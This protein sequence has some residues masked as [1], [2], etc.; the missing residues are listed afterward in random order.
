ME[1]QSLLSLFSSNPDKYY[2]VSLFDDKGFKRQNC[3]LCGKYFWS[4]KDKESCPEHENYSFI[5]DPPTQKRL[6]FVNAWKELSS[7]FKKNNHEIVHRYPVVCRWREDLYFTIASIVDFQRVMNGKIVFEI[8]KNPLVVPQMCLRFNDIENVGLTGRHYTSFCMIGQTC[9]ADV[10]GG[11]WKDKCI[12]LDHSLLKDVF[13]IKSD[14]ITF[15]EDVW[16]GAGAF[17]YSLEYY[18]RGLELGNAVFTEFEGDQYNYR[19]L[20]NKI[21]DMGAGL[22]RLSW[23]TL[24]TP[25]SYDATFGPV[26]RKL[27]DKFSIDID[28]KSELLSQY[29]RRFSNMH[30]HYQDDVTLLKTNI[31][32]ELGLTFESLEKTISP[33]ETLS[34]IAD[35]SRTLMFAISDGCL[36]SN[37][38]GGYNLRIVL[39]RTLA[40]LARFG[41]NID[42][43][44]VMDMHIEQLE[45]MYPEL[46]E[47]KNDVRTIIQIESDR[48]SSSK[49][50]MYQIAN[51][52]I[53]SKKSPSTDDLIRMYESDGI[54]PDFLLESGVIEKIPPDF[55]V[56][57]SELHTSHES[58]QVLDFEPVTG[59]EPTRL[60]YYENESTREFDARVLKVLKDK[61]LILDKTAFYPRGG[62]QEPDF[63]SIENIRITD[64][65]KQNNIVLHKM[66][67][68]SKNLFVKNKVVHGII[69]STR[70]RSITK[71]HSATHILNSAARNNLGS[72][73]WQNSAFKDEHYARLDITHHSALTKEQIK[74]IEKTANEVVQKNLPIIINIHERSDAESRYTFR[75]YQGG[76]VPSNNVRIVNI[77]GWDVEACGGTHVN[78]TGEIGL[79]KIL[80]TERIQDGVVRLEFVSGNNALQ[81]VQSQDSQL[82][83]I[84]K[85]L[86]SSREK[87]GESF[88]KMI[89][90]NELIKRKL[91]AIVNKFSDNMASTIPQKATRTKVGIKIYG[92]YDDQVGDDYYIAL[93]EKSTCV[94][95][96]L[97]FVALVQDQDR[98]RVIVFAG[99]ESRKI[100][101]ASRIAKEISLVLGGTGGGGTDKFAQGGG[102][103]K[104]KV[105][106]CLKNLES[107]IT[108]ILETSEKNG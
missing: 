94:D 61:Y 32:K 67:T 10:A 43:A 38:G 71:N 62:G 80:R 103:D 82:H 90:E 5:G 29:F 74:Q 78:K 87:V 7:F 22:E 48:Y 37:V 46:K 70:R 53:K 91:R 92:T 107:L 76:A 49:E 77:D 54:T 41:W 51:S 11:Y 88:G 28:S 75:I 16:M 58:K 6:D 79:I 27:A 17:G 21:I 100:L 39:R 106:D 36:P 30:T 105:Q 19:T 97:V 57:L 69:D 47:H 24:G 96:F 84:A 40:L 56:K 89:A 14:E 45:S 81:Y 1:K 73:V 8:P 52:M 44:E 59:I 95:P 33:F 66:Q 25:T 64:V 34:I 65:V 68:P 93:G 50:R 86:G 35:H 102:R 2:K 60:L 108:S 12:E 99:E 42:L 85:S 20:D 26:I 18:V 23:I 72:W 63:G 98:I 83:S 9:N 3:K 31:A 13:G 4:I 55:Y 15:V 104:N 101:K